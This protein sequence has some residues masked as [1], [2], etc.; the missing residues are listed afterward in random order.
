MDTASAKF[1]AGAFAERNGYDRRSLS[2]LK[3]DN[4][5]FIFVLALPQDEDSGEP[6]A[7]VVASDG[8]CRICPL[9]TVS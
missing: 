3:K 1:K 2:F 7:V 8:Q 9:F 6:M 5:S 4:G